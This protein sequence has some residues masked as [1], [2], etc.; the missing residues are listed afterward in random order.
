VVLLKKKVFVDIIPKEKF[1]KMSDNEV[2]SPI[3]SNGKDHFDDKMIEGKKS[4]EKNIE[5]DEDHSSSTNNGFGEDGE[6]D[7]KPR[8]VT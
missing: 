6:P 7:Y 1:A 4:N 5:S 3:T 2:M 8:K